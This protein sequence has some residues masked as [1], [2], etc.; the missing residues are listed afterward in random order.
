MKKRTLA[1]AVGLAS[2]DGLLLVSGV[3]WAQAEETP[4]TVRITNREFTDEPE[5]RRWVDEDGIEHV[6][7]QLVYAFF[8]NDMVGTIRGWRSWDLDPAAGHWFEHG[9]YAFTG[10]IL[11]EL[12]TGVGRFTWEGNR[13]EGVWTYTG[14]FLMHLD[15]GGLVEMS[16]T[17]QQDQ[18]IILQGILLDPPGGAKRNGPRSK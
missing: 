13:I 1:I 12:T 5:T 3:A 8:R 9:Y 18:P 14:D 11:G 17:V 4:I 7:D 2:M 16:A 6:R 15:D 10:R